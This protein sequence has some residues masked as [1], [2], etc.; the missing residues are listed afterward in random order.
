LVGKIPDA[1]SF[2]KE[3]VKEA[4]QV[5]WDSEMNSPT[6]I[7]Y[8]G[9]PAS[10]ISDPAWTKEK[11]R[12]R[13][14]SN[15]SRVTRRRTS[16]RSSSLKGRVAPTR[17]DALQQNILQELFLTSRKRFVRIAYRILENNE[18]AEDAVQDAF[19]SAC[20]HFGKF[21]GR[22]SLT[23]WLTRIVMN[24]A[25]M[26]RRKRK[27][28]RCSFHE[29][30]AAMSPF[31]ETVPDTQP[32]PE[33]AYSRAESYEILEAHL[34]ELNPLLRE[35]VVRTYYDELSITEASSAVG[36]PL[37]TYKA[38]LFRGRRLLQ[39]SGISPKKEPSSKP[40]QEKVPPIAEAPQASTVS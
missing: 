37:G 33:L 23:T 7:T 39:K 1:V 20:R 18:D 25:L 12:T 4:L 16:K 40:K 38:R 30:D 15:L 17:T 9:L 8:P 36:V 35:A 34:K 3:A 6:A 13:A 32:N 21:E 10:V 11:V 26:A 5:E 31:A 29:M 22:C 24:A 2:S 14:S 27:N 28:T 19:V